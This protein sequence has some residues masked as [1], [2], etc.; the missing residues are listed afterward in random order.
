MV[1]LSELTTRKLVWKKMVRKA[2]TKQRNTTRKVTLKTN[3]DPVQDLLAATE[4][5]N[6][7]VSNFVT[8]AAYEE[9]CEEVMNGDER[10][11]LSTPKS[12]DGTEKSKKRIDVL[13]FFVSILRD[14]I[15][16][17]TVSVPFLLIPT[18]TMSTM[19]QDSTI[20]DT[21]SIHSSLMHRLWN[22]FS[23]DPTVLKS[24]YVIRLCLN[25]CES[26]YQ[27]VARESFMTY[28]SLATQTWLICWAKSIILMQNE[29]SLLLS[30][31][32]HKVIGEHLLLQADE[33]VVTV[34]ALRKLVRAPLFARLE[35]DLHNNQTVQH[36]YRIV[37]Q[38]HLDATVWAKKEKRMMAER[39]KTKTAT[40][41]QPLLL[42]N[43]NSDLTHES[44]DA[45]ASD[46]CRKYMRKNLVTK[47]RK[48]STEKDRRKSRSPVAASSDSENDSETSYRSRTTAMKKQKQHH[49]EK[50]DNDASDCSSTNESARSCSDASTRGRTYTSHTTAR[51]AVKPAD[52]IDE[53]MGRGSS[54][55]IGRGVKKGSY[56]T[57][58][59]CTSIQTKVCKHL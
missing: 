27:D 56:D 49:R 1:N 10:Q 36:L 40:M 4:N 33:I 34:H 59:P 28:I 11:V 42:V 41:K 54:R 57:S 44:D 46:D 24:G 16:R 23:G 15:M 45:N 21:D 9:R 2:V 50:S 18:E 3:K 22:H 7:S 26:S 17:S 39:P 19:L 31:M 13:S 35:A 5:G 43:D 6:G 8:D 47:K 12:N 51:R 37:H 14:L 48:H 25:Y 55:S 30:T 29:V 52:V 38:Q 20:R 53:I 58:Y 32:D